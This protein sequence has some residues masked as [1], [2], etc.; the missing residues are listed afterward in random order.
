VGEFMIKI[1]T[2]N[3]FLSVTSGRE[4]EIRGLCVQ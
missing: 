1:N 2:N 3:F 4:E